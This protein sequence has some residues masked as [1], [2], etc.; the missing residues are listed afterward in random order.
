MKY[1]MMFIFHLNCCKL[2]I[3]YVIIA[4][5]YVC[6]EEKDN[7]LYNFDLVIF[8]TCIVVFLLLYD[9]LIPS[10]QPYHPHEIVSFYS[11]VQHFSRLFEW[12]T[13]IVQIKKNKP[14][15]EMMDAI[16]FLLNQMGADI[17]GQPRYCLN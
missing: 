16:N 8:Q 10:P 6:D 9:I 11:S 7:E 12:E 3:S 1:V 15:T 13:P 14:L 2:N 5:L 17:W 4:Y